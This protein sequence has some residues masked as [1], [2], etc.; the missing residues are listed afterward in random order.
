MSKKRVKALTLNIKPAREGLV[1]INPITGQPLKEEGEKVQ[2]STYWHR[3]LKDGDV[4]KVAKEAKDTGG[5]SDK[6]A[7]KQK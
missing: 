1:V 7:A 4:V 6:K 3:R 5:T 2:A